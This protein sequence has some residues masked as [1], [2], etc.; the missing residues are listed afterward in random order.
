MYEQKYHV[1]IR[2]KVTGEKLALEVWAENTDAATHKLTGTLIGPNCE[3]AWTGTGPLYEN[4]RLIRRE[5]KN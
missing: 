1:G 5:V 4:N 3:Y 2:H